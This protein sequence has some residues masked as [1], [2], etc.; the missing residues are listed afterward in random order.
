MVRE[1]GAFFF[2]M[3]EGATQIIGEEGLPA[4]PFRIFPGVRG[5]G[6]EL[7]TGFF[8]T[9]AGRS[10]KTGKIGNKVWENRGKR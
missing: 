6:R 4:E 10:G 8:L 2:L 5:G 7:G 9:S 3:F 1:E